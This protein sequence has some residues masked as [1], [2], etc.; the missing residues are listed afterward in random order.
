M[1]GKVVRTWQGASKPCSSA[2]LLPNGNILRPCHPT[3]MKQTI[4]PGMTGPN[5][6]R[7]QEFTWDG[8][9][10]WDF[11]LSTPTQLSH[12]DVCKLPNGNVLMIAWEKLLVILR[13]KMVAGAGIEPA[14]QGFSVL[15][16]TD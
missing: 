6:G 15:C 11:T 14:T 4:I 8:E 1:Q 12:H 3:E 13:R 9:L 10:V 7:I 2:Y 16:S 5:G